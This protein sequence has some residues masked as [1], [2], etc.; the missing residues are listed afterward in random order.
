MKALKGNLDQ[1]VEAVDQ[2][3]KSGSFRLADRGSALM[4]ADRFRLAIRS[5]VDG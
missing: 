2:D 4:R 1:F 5:A 3:R